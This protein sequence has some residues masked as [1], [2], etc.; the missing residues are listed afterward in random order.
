MMP[1]AVAVCP[2]Y[3]LRSA[4][5]Y[6]HHALAVRATP[7]TLLA[8]EHLPASVALSLLPV[9]C[10]RSTA[11]IWTPDR[12]SSALLLG[13]HQPHIPAHITD[14]YRPVFH[15]HP[16]ILPPFPPMCHR[17]PISVNTFPSNFGRAGFSASPLCNSLAVFFVLE[18]RFVLTSFHAFDN[19]RLDRRT[20]ETDRDRAEG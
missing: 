11:S 5:V 13:C 3:R 1:V 2:P 20:Y 15:R 6:V 9:P 12:Q 7:V 10:K 17:R 8:P 19:L 18:L 4:P 16:R 14:T